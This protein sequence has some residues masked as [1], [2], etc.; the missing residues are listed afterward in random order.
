MV[1][2]LLLVMAHGVFMFMCK[3]VALL[4]SN[5]NP[6]WVFITCVC[7]F[8]LSAR[9]SLQ[10]LSLLYRAKTPNLTI[11]IFIF[12]QFGPH[13]MGGS[14]VVSTAFTMTHRL[15]GSERLE[16][17]G[18]AFFLF[19][20][21]DSP[22]RTVFRFPAKYEFW[23]WERLSNGKCALI[24][25]SL[26]TDSICDNKHY[27]NVGTVHDFAWLAY[28][29]SLGVLDVVLWLALKIKHDI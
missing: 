15:W 26:S 22:I 24:L 21:E 17:G 19:C 27:N 1:S 23:L 4:G 14:F 20:A 18:E 9:G 5:W 6:L 12:T 13:C 11:D 7:K 29:Y 8:C 2:R 28:S 16:F 25:L 3:G 10:A